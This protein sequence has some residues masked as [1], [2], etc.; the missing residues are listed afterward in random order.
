MK[1]EWL[2]SLNKN[3]LKA[4]MSQKKAVYLHAGAGTGKTTTLINRIIHLTRDLKI[5]TKNILAITFTNNAAREMKDRLANFFEN[6]QF[7]NLTITTFHSLG[8]SILRKY[9]SDLSLNLNSYFNIV[10]E[11]ESK[12]IIKNA[13][14]E[15]NLSKDIYQVDYLKKTFSKKKYSDIEIQILNELDRTMQNEEWFS[16]YRKNKIILIFEETKIFNK[17]NEY[18][19]KTNQLDFEDL[20]VYTYKL[21]T[22]HNSAVTS[23]YNKTFQHILIDEFQ[24]IDLIQYQIIKILGQNNTVFVVGD[25]N[26]N[27]YSFRG[28]NILCNNL[29]LRDFK[30]Q[31]ISLNHNYR[32][33]QNILDKANLLISYN[34]NQKNNYFQNFLKN[35][36]L[37]GEQVIYKE[38]MDNEKESSFISQQIQK[39][40]YSQN[41]NFSD[42]AVLYRMNILHKS[43]ENSFII[44]NIPYMIK[45][46]LSFFQTK[47]VKDFISYI[48]T[49]INPKND[50]DLKRIINMPPRKIGAKKIQKLEKIANENQVSF[51][52]AIE[53]LPHDDKDKKI[54]D[55]FKKLFQDL[56]KDFFDENKCN[57]DNVIFLIDQH[58]HYVE[59]LEENKEKN[60]HKIRKQLDNLQKIFVN[61]NKENK[62][63]SF[64]EKLNIL[65]N[66]ISL[67]Q[68]DEEEE[69]PN[70]VFMSTIHKVKGLEFKVVFSIG[71]EQNFFLKDRKDDPENIK[72]E[73][74]ISYVAIT[75]AKEI[76]YIT[77]AKKRFLQGSS[78]QTE[79]I[80]FLKEMKLFPQKKFLGRNLLHSFKKEQKTQN[81]FTIG[82]KI[83]HK[84]FGVGLIVAHNKDV[85][86]IVFDKKYGIKK[87][88][89]NHEALMKY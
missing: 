17:Y 30:S 66:K 56:Q 8:A 26:Q 88:V 81:I 38:F 61:E 5:D 39:L 1:K 62:E 69:Q 33:T 14:K 31:T 23:F 79:P 60:D 53:F 67:S 27:I 41:Y 74:R 4:V 86:S 29:F 58:I 10:G 22:K 59:L 12:Q 35:N 21:L 64:L 52:E 68:Y 32:S 6:S 25:P 63:G 48:K 7:S 51:F 18:L 40:V 13:V 77:S 15:L 9:I 87:I 42:I 46:T 2:N 83:K 76:L 54:I 28:A 11:K 19:K 24:D 47:T 45:N 70:K 75:R 50:L 37:P 65:L 84:I 85:L 3:Q 34:Y 89:S 44:K 16:R 80:S 78:I 73:R 55:N 43:I 72:E 20:I 36:S 49:L 82:E 71:W 57:L